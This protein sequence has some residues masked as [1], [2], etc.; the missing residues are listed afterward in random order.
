MDSEN[1]I[2]DNEHDKSFDEYINE[3]RKQFGYSNRHNSKS[4][5]QLC[6][7]NNKLLRESG[8]SLANT[9]SHL[10]KLTMDRD[11]NA[12]F[13]RSLINTAFS[14]TNFIQ[15]VPSPLKESH[16]CEF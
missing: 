15:T 11:N 4:R 7:S 1:E 9:K 10:S 12:Y 6:K 2:N 14:E 8:G 5:S 3:I 16:P 13:K